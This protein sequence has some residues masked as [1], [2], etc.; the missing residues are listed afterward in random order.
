MDGKCVFPQRTIDVI[1]IY[2]A[3]GL[4]INIGDMEDEDREIVITPLMLSQHMMYTN[5]VLGCLPTPWRQALPSQCP[6]PLSSHMGKCLPFLT[7][8]LPPGQ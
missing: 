2:L 8:D 4:T 7:F 5:Q 6:Q 1:R 3:H